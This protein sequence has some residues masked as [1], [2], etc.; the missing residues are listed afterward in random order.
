MRWHDRRRRATAGTE[1][2][3]DPPAAR[4]APGGRRGALGDVVAAAA[5][6]QARFVEKHRDRLACA[7]KLT[8]E[9]RARYLDL[10]AELATVRDDLLAYVGAA[11]FARLFPDPAAS[12]ETPSP[13]S[14]QPAGQRTEPAFD[15]LLTVL[16]A[17]ADRLA[18]R[19]DSQTG[20]TGATLAEPRRR[21][22]GRARREQGAS[23]GGSQWR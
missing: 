14:L 21:G 11:R 3:T 19:R 10:V 6:D 9:T 17:A 22:Q 5:A 7:D 20:G 2:P 16:R 12:T 15:Q 8:D 4:A 18:H 13:V 23:R 1:R